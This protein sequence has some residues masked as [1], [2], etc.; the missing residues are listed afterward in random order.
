MA[1]GVSP[2]PFL[3]TAHA[4]K[5]GSAGGPQWPRQLKESPRLYPYLPLVPL[6]TASSGLV[7]LLIRTLLV[8]L[9]LP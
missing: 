1:M 6:G 5:E 7:S 8:L 3:I 4:R 2:G 9:G